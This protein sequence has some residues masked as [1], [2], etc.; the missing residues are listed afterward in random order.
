LE[1]WCLN[2]SQE[3]KYTASDIPQHAIPFC[4]VLLFTSKK[5][6]PSQITSD[7]KIFQLPKPINQI[8]IQSEYKNKQ[9]NP[10]NDFLTLLRSVLTNNNCSEQRQRLY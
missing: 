7:I 1:Q 8:I 6:Q 9:I 5:P 4:I 2:Y 3:K 10:F